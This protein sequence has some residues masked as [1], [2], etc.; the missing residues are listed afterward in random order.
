M[1]TSWSVCRVAR[2]GWKLITRPLFVSNSTEAPAYHL[3][4]HYGGAVRCLTY[5]WWSL[6]CVTL[7]TYSPCVMRKSLPSL[8]PPSIPTLQARP[9]LLTLSATPQQSAAA[10]VLKLDLVD[11]PAP[12]AH[13][14]GHPVGPLLPP[15]P[16]ALGSSHA[17]SLQLCLTTGAEPCLTI[18][19]EGDYHC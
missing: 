5:L 16:A 10:P 3:Q 8:L 12:P 14:P 15:V 2:Y 13:N 17:S 4:Q 18:R 19:L 6:S 9:S 7:T 11:G 1:V